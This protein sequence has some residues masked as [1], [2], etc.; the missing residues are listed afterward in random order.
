M[1]EKL[2][3]RSDD[4]FNAFDE[5]V[6][7]T[8]EGA[9]AFHALLTDYRDV[10]RKVSAI[11]DIEHRSDQITHHAYERL[12]MQF[13]TPFDRSEIHRLL[14]KIDDVLDLTDAA[15]ERL[16][17]Y[18]IPEILPP[19]KELSQLLVQCCEVMQQAVQNLRSIKKPK[20][21]LDA[22]HQLHDLEAEADVVLRTSMAK[23]FKSG[24]D[25]LTVIKWKEIYDLIESATDRCLDVANIVEGVVLEHS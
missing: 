20:Q 17:R 15:A 18:E 1:L 10:A 24:L 23:L 19:A 21:I 2:M 14:S 11:K 6:A 4:F 22:C 12:H 5:Q 16:V 25:P 13:I 9:H 8:V 7:A 3:P